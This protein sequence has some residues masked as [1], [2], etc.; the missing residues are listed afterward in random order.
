M[1]NAEYFQEK[2]HFF[3]HPVAL[4]K[5]KTNHHIDRIASTPRFLPYN[6]LGINSFI[7]IIYCLCYLRFKKCSEIPWMG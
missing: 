5:G 7:C 4:E 3:N 6:Q 1:Y 2:I